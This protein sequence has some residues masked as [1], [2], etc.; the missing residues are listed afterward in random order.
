MEVGSQASACPAEDPS[1]S[2]NLRLLKARP[3][4]V[5][6]A[7]LMCRVSHRTG[8]GDLVH[9]GKYCRAHVLAVGKVPC[10]I[11]A[12]SEKEDRGTAKR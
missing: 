3:C 12:L 10:A 5:S 2:K 6:G 11:F 1:L 7:A 4:L 8:L 9:A